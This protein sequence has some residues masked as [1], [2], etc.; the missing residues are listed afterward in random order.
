VVSVWAPNGATLKFAVPVTFK[1]N[2]AGAMVIYQYAEDLG[3]MVSGWVQTG[4]WTVPPTVTVTTNP[5]GLQIIVDLVTLTAPQTFQWTPGSNH[6][7]AVA[8]YQGSG[9]ARYIF[10]NWSD[11]ASARHTVTAP[12]SNTTYTA[13][14]TYTVTSATMQGP[15]WLQVGLSYMPFDVY[16]HAHLASS[17]GF[18]NSC[19]SGSSVRG[20]FQK[21]LREL[22]AQGVSGVRIFFEFCG[23]AYSTPL[24]GC[25]QHWSSVT[26]PNAAWVAN[27]REFFRDVSDADIANITITP[28]HHSEVPQLYTMPKAAVTKPGPDH[29]YDT[30]DPV[31]FDTASPFGRKPHVEGG[32][33]YYWPVGQQDNE[34]ARNCAPINPHFIG[35]QN[36][37]NVIN[38]MLY[39]A[40]RTPATPSG[41]RFT[42]FE[43]DFEQEMDLA[44][45][46][47]LSRFI[48]DNAQVTSGEPRVLDALRY[49]MSVNNFD[50][51]R[52]A[53]AAPWPASSKAGANCLNVYQD[54][55]R[56]M[57]QD[58]I[59]S[60]FVNSVWPTLIV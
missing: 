15:T 11:G 34:N 19:P 7:I 40:D 54:Y 49:Y 29:C 33:T 42:V 17:Y 53:F 45:F 10:S 28:V 47:V 39:E 6:T 35:W 5:P 44:A 16:D 52:V 1:P 50:P 24:S 9:G 41:Q 22:R 8:T 43:L 27:V 14:F 31:Y 55:A 51:S 60:E 23:G 12:S 4:T 59:A 46:P 38:A 18:A 30:P 32:K 26:G 21:V 48:Y 3:G 56:L 25:G 2:Y 36:Q 20:C 37:Y 13:N 57:G 58:Q